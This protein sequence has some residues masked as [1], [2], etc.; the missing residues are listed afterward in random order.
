MVHNGGTPRREVKYVGRSSFRVRLSVRSAMRRWSRG[1][2]VAAA[3][4]GA[5]VAAVAGGGD[6]AVPPLVRVRLPSLGGGG[7]C[8]PPS[9][10][11]PAVINAFS[12]PYNR[13]NSGL[14]SLVSPRGYGK[15]G[16]EAPRP[17]LAVVAVKPLCSILIVG[18][19]EPSTTL[20]AAPFH[21]RSEPLSHD[22]S[23]P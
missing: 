2:V 20:N 10:T 3:A 22:V 19:V 7:R 5:A 8:E 17:S 4:A 11:P 23:F 21:W 15:R 1:A 18:K 13:N 16:T 9:P 6:G 12:A 14:V